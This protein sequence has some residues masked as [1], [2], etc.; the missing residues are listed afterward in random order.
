LAPGD[1]G[2]VDSLIADTKSGIY[3]DGPC[4]T[5][6][7]HESQGFQ[8]F[9]AKAWK[10]KDGK[11]IGRVQNPS[12]RA[13]SAHFWKNC[14]AV[15]GRDSWDIYGSYIDGKGRPNHTV[16]QSNGTSPARFTDVMIGLNKDLPLITDLDDSV[17]LAHAES[18]LV[19]KPKVSIHI[20]KPI[21]KRADDEV[22]PTVKPGI[23]LP[24]E[25]S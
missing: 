10:I 7:D 12:I 20:E 14:D 21:E 13:S 17:F 11:L 19:P 15:C 16:Q 25:S 3:I 6:H 5:S 9:G 23:S 24:E 2:S 1:S 22:E 8:L 4:E 18:H